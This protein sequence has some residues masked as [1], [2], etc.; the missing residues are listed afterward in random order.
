[1][2]YYK[3]VCSIYDG[4][5]YKVGVVW[6][7]VVVVV[8]VK[9]TMMCCWLALLT[10][11]I[12]MS[13]KVLNKWTMRKCVIIYIYNELRRRIRLSLK[14]IFNLKAP[15]NACISFT[16]SCINVVGTKRDGK[17]VQFS[18]CTC[19]VVLRIMC[20]Q[21]WNNTATSKIFIK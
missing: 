13:A 5:M 11:C 6:R 9:T 17:V 14:N 2:N 7:L 16:I 19:V 8:V 12:C 10:V 15:S 18:W 21:M 3:S 4:Y 20:V 1:M